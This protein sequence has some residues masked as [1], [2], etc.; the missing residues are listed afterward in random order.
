M[1]STAQ[2]DVELV[3]TGSEL[4]DGRRLNTHGQLL[5]GEL[6]KLGLRLMRD[7]TVPDGPDAMHDA[8]LSALSRVEIVFITGGLGPT[9]DDVTREVVAKI[10]SRGVVMHE[11]TREYINEW[12]VKRGRKS[13]PA[14][15][16][17]ALVVEGATVLSNRA[18]LSAGELVEFNGKALILLP[19]PPHELRAIMEDHVMPWLRTRMGADLPL[20]RSFRF[21]GIGESEIARRLESA[22]FTED[23]MEV[24]YCARPGDVELRFTVP[25]PSRAKFDESV[26]LVRKLFGSEAYSETNG[27]EIPLERIV[28]EM[29][30]ERKL[31]LATAESCTGGLIGHRITNVSG[32][33]DYFRGGVSAYANEVKQAVLGV[34]RE[35]LAAHGAVSEATA[36]EM[37][38]GVRR[39]LGADIGLSTTGIAGPSGGTAEKP[40]G[41]VYIGVADAN[42]TVVVER[43]TG[44]AREFIKTISAQAALDLLRRRLLGVA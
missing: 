40:V 22:G 9:S 27:E 15:D 44:G 35:T 17:H 19:G 21:A 29:L 43:R 26:A 14:F 3:S 33:S 8:I 42:G 12:L 28:G 25:P 37:A 10:T 36:R 2:R 6:S 4:L 30:R 16:R 18:G 41:L 24:A 34:K 7:T 20:C 31:T 1:S 32:S 11:P 39:A 38:E 5:G 23:G 13:Y